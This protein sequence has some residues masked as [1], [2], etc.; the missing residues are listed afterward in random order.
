[1]QKFLEDHFETTILA[2]MMLFSGGV[3]VIMTLVVVG[4]PALV[5]WLIV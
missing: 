5:E 2:T 1:M 4:V 3:A